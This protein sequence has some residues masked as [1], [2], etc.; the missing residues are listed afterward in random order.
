MPSLT[1]VYRAALA[2]CGRSGE[3]EDL[4]RAAFLK[5]LERFDTFEP[6]A[7]CRAWLLQIMRN[8]RFDQ[9]SYCALGQVSQKELA[10]VLG[11]VL[12]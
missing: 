12:P 10:A 8:I 3:A 5:A 1:T 2:V 6:G 4:T 7:N 11:A 9:Y